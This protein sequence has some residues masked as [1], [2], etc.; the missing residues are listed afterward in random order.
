MSLTRSFIQKTQVPHGMDPDT[1]REGEKG[2]EPLSDSPWEGGTHF[3]HG[4]GERAVGN[5]CAD[6][7]TNKT[8]QV[9]FSPP[10]LCLLRIQGCTQKGSLVDR[11]HLRLPYFQP[12]F[13][14]PGSLPHGKP[15][16]QA[17]HSGLLLPAPPNTSTGCQKDTPSTQDAGYFPSST[18]ISSCININSC[19]RTNAPFHM[20]AAKRPSL[21]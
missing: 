6:E 10:S 2:T 3:L 11:V 1:Q 15:A 16:H 20:R 14:G 13:P 7:H 19:T 4:A 9:C 5:S 17:C 8:C 12:P 18:L 21:E